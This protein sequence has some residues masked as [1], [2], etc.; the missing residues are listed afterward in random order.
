MY[1]RIN[2]EVK[3]PEPFLQR[4][5]FY[6]LNV[7]IC[8][9]L[10]SEK[11]TLEDWVTSNNLMPQSKSDSY[12]SL[13]FQLLLYPLSLSVSIISLHTKKERQSQNDW[14]RTVSRVN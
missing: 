3:I 2:Q 10:L 6:K 12:F 4:P 13:L 8:I 5:Y 9:I 7:P 1:F 14:T 11:R